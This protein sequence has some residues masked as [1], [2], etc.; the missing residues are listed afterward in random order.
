MKDHL[1]AIAH[2]L[3]SELISSEALL[4]LYA[5]AQQLPPIPNILLECRLGAEDS[6]VDF[7]V[8][9]P[10]F[11]N[12]S[13]PEISRNADFSGV[14]FTDFS[15]M[16]HPIWQHYQSILDTYEH[17]HNSDLTLAFK[18][19]EDTIIKYSPVKCFWLEFDIES[20]DL[21]NFIPA[22]GIEIDKYSAVK[23]ENF[24]ELWALDLLCNLGVDGNNLGSLEIDRLPKSLIENLD[25]CK[26]LL[27]QDAKIIFIGA[28]PS[29][30]AD[31]LR[32]IID[33]IP[34]C[35]ITRYLLEIGWGGVAKELE[36]LIMSLSNLV[37]NI[38]LSFNVGEI[39][40]PRIGLECYFID[41]PQ[42]EYR[43]QIFVD[44]LVEA[45][46]CSPSKGKAL[47]SWVEMEKAGVFERFTACTKIVYQPHKPLEAKAYL[48]L[49]DN[50]IL[51][52]EQEY[53]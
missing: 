27:P 24:L 25:K 43:W 19:A 51:L 37:D 18:G 23:D 48:G 4:H 14:K 50:T 21:N 35:E 53:V 13:N 2:L 6:R 34:P 42:I 30:R 39:V 32:L 11:K 22:I 12:R 33:R 10:P 47:L 29:V 15:F 7:S 52:M 46:L 40:F 36:E 44:Y 20:K 3:P 45:N 8:P 17:F 41:P 9:L 26:S 16:S 31:T 38:V 5:I 28:N 1:E 49:W